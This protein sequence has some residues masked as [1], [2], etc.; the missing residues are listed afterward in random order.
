MY[1]TIVWVVLLL[2]VS[3]SF[4]Y[5]KDD[6]ALEAKG[7]ARFSDTVYVN[8]SITADREGTFGGIKSSGAS[9]ITDSSAS[10]VSVGS[11]LQAEK[12]LTS[13][14]TSNLEGDLILGGHLRRTSTRRAQA[15]STSF[16]G[17][18]STTGRGGDINFNAPNGN[19]E[20]QGP[21]N[22]NSNHS[23]NSSTVINGQAIF[24]G[25]L[26]TTGPVQTQNLRATELNAQTLNAQNIDTQN[27]QSTQSTV[28]NLNVIGTLTATNAATSSASAVV[29]EE[30]FSYDARFSRLSG[31]NSA[32]SVNN[33]NANQLNVGRDVSVSDAQTDG[34][35]QAGSLRVLGDSSLAGNT[36]TIGPNNGPV[37]VS[38]V[39]SSS[40]T[41]PQTFVTG[42]SSDCQN[43]GDINLQ[44]GS[45]TCPTAAPGV[46]GSVNIESSGSL[47][48][49]NIQTEQGDVNVASQ[50]TISGSSITFEDGL[51]VTRSLTLGTPS[52]EA[53][54]VTANAER[55]I[56]I[57][58]SNLNGTGGSL[59]L[60]G[61]SSGS[62]ANPNTTGEVSLVSA[63]NILVG[64]PDTSTIVAGNLAA[65][66]AT[67]D[68]VTI[69]GEA[70]SNTLVVD[71]SVNVASDVSLV[72]N[73]VAGT[74]L[75][76][77]TLGRGISRNN[78]APTTFDVQSP[79]FSI[80][81]GDA[82][83]RS[84]NGPNGGTVSLE[85]GYGTQTSGS[86]QITGGQISLSN[87][88]DQTRIEGQLIVDSL[89]VGSGL[90]LGEAKGDYTVAA[91]TS[92]LAIS[93]QSG[94]QG[95]DLILNSGNAGRLVVGPSA[96]AVNFAG[97]LNIQNNLQTSAV[98]A[99]TAVVGGDARVDGNTINLG[100][101][102]DVTLTRTPA[103]TALGHATI[104]SGQNAQI[105]QGGDLSLSAGA[106]LQSGSEGNVQFTGD[107]L[108]IRGQ[109]V[110]LNAPNSTV[111]FTST[112]RIQVAS[113]E[114]TTTVYG[115]LTQV[116]TGNAEF[117]KSV[118]ANSLNA[119]GSTVLSS[120][121]TSVGSV[122]A[123]SL[124][125]SGNL[126]VKGGVSSGNTTAGS[127][128]V[129]G[130][131]DGQSLSATDVD[132]S[133][134]VVS[135][136][137][138]VAANATV[139]HTLYIE[140]GATVG[141]AL[142]VSGLANL[143]TANAP[144]VTAESA[145]AQDLTA[146]GNVAVTGGQVRSAHVETG[147]LQATAITADQVYTE[148]AASVGGIYVF[149]NLNN[150]G[151]AVTATSATVQDMAEGFSVNAAT[152]LSVSLDAVVLEQAVVG[153][154]TTVANNLIAGKTAR[155]SGGLT[156]TSVAV[157]GTANLGS[158]EAQTLIASQPAVVAGTFSAN[159]TN[160]RSL[161]GV[162]DAPVTVNGP[163][164][165]GNSAVVS[166]NYVQNSGVFNVAGNLAANG[167]AVD[168]VLTNSGYIYSNALS[169]TNATFEVLEADRIS[170]A[171]LNIS[172]LFIQGDVSGGNLNAASAEVQ[173]TLSAS[174]INTENVTATEVDTNSALVSSVTANRAE[175]NGRTSIES[176]IVLNSESS[177]Q[178]FGAGNQG[179]NLNIGTSTNGDAI[180]L[181]ANLNVA[182]GSGNN[183]GSVYL[184]GN[185]VR[186]ISQ[187][188]SVS[189]DT[190]SPTSAQSSVSFSGVIQL[191]SSASDVNIAGNVAFN[192][193]LSATSISAAGASFAEELT[194]GSATISSLRAVAAE[195]DNVTFA[196]AQV[197]S[198]EADTLNGQN[199]NF[200]DAN[201][202]NSF[203]VEAASV[204]S[205]VV[206]E[207][208]FVSSDLSVRRGVVVG[209]DIIVNGQASLSNLVAGDVE[210]ETVSVDG[211]L[212]TG[213]AYFERDLSASGVS[214]FGRDLAVQGTLFPTNT[215]QAENNAFVYGNF[216]STAGDV[217][218]SGILNINSDF[219]VS[220]VNAR[221]SV[222]SAG[223]AN[224]AGSLNV[225][226][227]VAVGGDLSAASA[228]VNNLDVFVG[229][230][231]SEANV[232]GSLIVQGAASVSGEFSAASI[233]AESLSLG[234]AGTVS[235]DISVLGNAAFVGSLSLTESASIAGDL[236]IS[237]ALEAAGGLNVAGRTIVGG[238]LQAQ[239]I[240]SEGALTAGVVNVAGSVSTE[241]VLSVEQ[242]SSVTGNVTTLAYTTNSLEASASNV[243]F[244]IANTA[245]IVGGL[246]GN[247]VL[248]ARR[249]LSIGYTLNNTG[250][251]NALR[252]QV[253]GSFITNGLIQTGS[254]NIAGTAEVAGNIEA[255]DLMNMGGAEVA[256]LS[257]D[258]LTV[259][260]T[261]SGD[262]AEA[263]STSVDNLSVS[264]L[265]SVANLEA[266]GPV[267]IGCAASICAP[268]TTTSSLEV[269]S[270]LNIAG[271]ADVAGDVYVDGRTGITGDL[272]ARTLV[273]RN[274][275]FQGSLT[276]TGAPDFNGAVAADRI[277]A[278]S[279]DISG[280]TSDFVNTDRFTSTQAFV[281][282]GYTNI[283]GAGSVEGMLDAS[284]NS[285]LSEVTNNG[286]LAV[287][288]TLTTSEVNIGGNLIVQGAY[289]VAGTNFSDISDL[290]VS[291]TVFGFTGSA[292]RIFTNQLDA[293]ESAGL[294]NLQVNN[295]ARFAGLINAS[296]ANA[297][298]AN[299][300]TLTVRET[301]R[302]LNNV[303]GSD[304]DAD[305]INVGSRGATIARLYTGEIESAGN[306]ESE[307]DIFVGGVFSAANVS[308][309]GDLRAISLSASGDAFT[310]DLRVQGETN[311]TGSLNGSTGTFNAAQG[312]VINGTTS[313]SGTV[314][315]NA[316]L[317]QS[318][319]N[320]LDGILSISGNARLDG[321]EVNA[322]SF[323]LAGDLIVPTLNVSGQLSVVQDTSVRG[324]IAFGSDLSVRGGSAFTSANADTITVTRNAAV[325][326]D[327]QVSGN[328]SVGANFFI[329][330]NILAGAN[331]LSVASS[332]RAAQLFAG[333]ANAGAFSTNTFV[334]NN[335][336]A[337]NIQ[338]TATVDEFSVSAESNT[339]N[340]G[341][342]DLLIG[343]NGVTVTTIFNPL[344]NLLVQQNTEV[345]GDVNV[346]RDLIAGQAAVTFEISAESADVGQLSG[347]DATLDG[348][349]NVA[350]DLRV[351]GSL[352]ANNISV[353]S[354]SNSAGLNVDSCGA[355]FGGSVT[356]TGATNINSDLSV[357]GELNTQ[358][359]V[360]F[361]TLVA[362]EL[363][364]ESINAA[365]LT[366]SALLVAGDVS[367]TSVTSGTQV[368]TG[369]VSSQG[370]NAPLFNAGGSLTASGDATFTT[371][372]VSGED[373]RFGCAT[374]SVCGDLLVSDSATVSNLNV[375]GALNIAQS[376][377]VEGVATVANS[378]SVARQAV[379]SGLSVDSLSVS[380]STTV[381]GTLT[382]SSYNGQDLSVSGP[383]RFDSA[384]AASVS[385]DSVV[386]SSA[387]IGSA[388]AA[389]LNV[390][391]SSSFSGSASALSA[392]FGASLGVTGNFSVEGN[393][394][395][396]LF[397]ASDASVAGV[398]Y[399]ERVRT[400]SVTAPAVNAETV[401][402]FSL[403][404]SQADVNGL[405]NVQGSLSNDGPAMFSS[406]S[407]AG[408]L[409]IDGILATRDLVVGRTLTTTGNFGTTDINVETTAEFAGLVNADTIT[410]F[411]AANVRTNVNANSA[412]LTAESAQSSTLGVDTSLFLNGFDN[413]IA[414]LQ[415]QD[416]A[417]P[418]FSAQLLAATD[419][420]FN[421]SI[422]AQQV[423][424]VS[425]AAASF[426][427]FSSASA[428]STQ[429]ST[430]STGP[431]QVD[432]TLTA[433]TLNAN[434]N[435]V[436]GSF[437]TLANTTVSGALA[438]SSL[439]I[440]GDATA[441]NA[442]VGALASANT[443]NA[444]AVSSNEATFESLNLGSLNNA[445]STVANGDLD[446]TSVAAQELSANAASASLASIASAT[447]SSLNVTGNQTINGNLAVAS[448]LSALS[449]ELASLTVA[450]PI[451]GQGSTATTANDILLSNDLR[452]N[453]FII[454]RN[455]FVNNL[456]TQSL[457]VNTTGDFAETLRAGSLEIAED[458]Q[459]YGGLH[460]A[461]SVGSGDNVFSRTL[462]VP[463][464]EAADGTT[465]TFNSG[466]NSARSVRVA[467]AFN[468][469]ASQLFTTANLRSGA[470]TAE[471]AVSVAS[472]LYVR[473]EASVSGD[474]SAITGD[475]RIEGLTAESITLTQALVASGDIYVANSLIGTTGSLN[476]N[477]LN[478]RG[479]AS[480]ATA[481][482]GSV[483]ADA[484]FTT[485]SDLS[486]LGAITVQGSVLTGAD[487]TVGGSTTGINALA[488][489]GVAFVTSLTAPAVTGRFGEN[490]EVNGAT[491]AGSFSVS[492]STT[493]EAGLVANGASTFSGDVLVEEC[494]NVAASGPVTVGFNLVANGESAVVFGSNV[495]T[496]DTYANRHVA[497]TLQTVG[498]LTVAG[499]ASLGDV[500]VTGNL[501]GAA[502]AYVFGGEFS[503][504]SFNA[505]GTLNV[506]ND[507][508]VNGSVAVGGNLNVGGA[509]LVS[510][511]TVDGNSLALGDLVVLGASPNAIFHG[512]LTVAGF[513]SIENNLQVVD[514][515]FV[516]GQLCAGETDFRNNVFINQSL[517]N[518]GSTEANTMFVGQG[519]S[520]G[521][522][523]AENYNGQDILIQGPLTVTGSYSNSDPNFAWNIAGDFAVTN[524]P[525]TSE[526]LI[527]G[528][529]T[530]AGDFNSESM[531]VGRDAVL[532][533]QGVI[534][535]GTLNAGGRIFSVGDDTFV[536][537]TTVGGILSV[538]S[539]LD[540]VGTT[541]ILTGLTIGTTLGV[542]GQV[543]VGFDAS[544]AGNLIVPGD[545]TA[546]Q[547]A[548][549][550]VTSVT[551]VLSVGG[552]AAFSVFAEVGT[553][554]SISGD[555]TSA[556]TGS[557]SANII[558]TGDLVVEN[559]LTIGDDTLTVP[560]QLTADSL[561]VS[562]D[563]SIAGDAILGP[564]PL[565]VEG[566][567]TVAQALTVYGDATLTG[568]FS[569]TGDVS[570]LGNFLAGDVVSD[571][572]T[573]GGSFTTEDLTVG[574]DV[575]IR[576]S[577]TTMKRGVEF[578]LRTEHMNLTEGTTTFNGDATAKDLLLYSDTKL[579]VA[580]DLIAK[581]ALS[582]DKLSA[583]SL[584][585]NRLVISG[586]YIT[587]DDT[588][589]IIPVPLTVS[590]PTQV[591]ASLSVS[592]ATVSDLVAQQ[593]DISVMHV[594]GKA[595][596][597]T[598]FVVAQDLTV[599]GNLAH[600]SSITLGQTIFANG[601]ALSADSLAAN[602][603]RAG[604]S[605]LKGSVLVNGTLQ[606][607]SS[608]T[609]D[610][611]VGS[612]TANSHAVVQ[613]LSAVSATFTQSST[614]S[615]DVKV[616]GHLNAAHLQYQDLS[617]D[618]EIA[619]T[620]TTFAGSVVVAQNGAATK[621]L[622]TTTL[623]TA[624]KLT[625]SGLALSY[626]GAASTS[627]V[628]HRQPKKDLTECCLQYL[629]NFASASAHALSMTGYTL[630]ILNPVQANSVVYRFETAGTSAA[631][632]VYRYDV[633]DIIIVKGSPNEGHNVVIYDHQDAI[634]T[635]KGDEQG[636]G[637]IYN[638]RNLVSQALGSFNR[639]L[640][641]DEV[642]L[643][644]YSPRVNAGSINGQKV[645][646]EW[647]RVGLGDA[648]F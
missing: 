635:L 476:T 381:Q 119:Q 88:N 463:N 68:Q 519:V 361:G 595:N 203:S 521:S 415:S 547:V 133:K 418:T 545:L 586:S 499:S 224:F 482:I 524:G 134:L 104:F 506:N 621:T 403:T 603:I 428:G 324:D 340:A 226:S 267:T 516:T 610:T 139:L 146:A 67:F 561:T 311:I 336:G 297:N 388:S 349:L 208:M 378:A 377:S 176:G 636:R 81:A 18:D 533:A 238:S 313:I 290:T 124:S 13:A 301:T 103:N 173:G 600:P 591:S 279:A 101:Q 95:G 256:S 280:L 281:A 395:A 488:S 623:N 509:L 125:T 149:G 128:N 460:V 522:L 618:F 438:A 316:A 614:I 306:L 69:T 640:N 79:T 504:D 234:A 164:T 1:K 342:N 221:G 510:N 135:G 312:V 479:R 65:R 107:N 93:G 453:D 492:G 249:T 371:L 555:L 109:E 72:G 85:A 585:V 42:Q 606:G 475:M 163:V 87:K 489:E 263:A 546:D 202:Q 255:S 258:S 113:S 439:Q 41:P 59:I 487:L 599:S 405:V 601:A 335:G 577:G 480:F 15:S 305:S 232:D 112:S 57:A 285:A 532:G 411:D 274:G 517:S 172:N 637:N 643:Y 207:G 456:E 328:F 359:A 40:L 20:V 74:P 554:V 108:R 185:T 575:Y 326:A 483:A 630:N 449:S 337:V 191:G 118:Y 622:S 247:G 156:A 535:A 62:G 252:G 617:G 10:S 380:G 9:T 400:G 277:N 565:D 398:A 470:V 77:F 273:F 122:D 598:N 628:A 262:S 24:G 155:F 461:G 116:P 434:G 223:S 383:S 632:L 35:L 441:G 220:S 594:A 151:A 284:G 270:N 464:L 363:T 583:S 261:L 648:N 502:G 348:N 294:T 195:F 497:T 132:S 11:V 469:E 115:D 157:D 31:S 307:N 455:L 531:E 28:Q 424:G 200:G 177:R 22:I 106:A 2:C 235:G 293:T 611:V 272:T 332:A 257:A 269:S 117:A 333:A 626:N 292:D 83:S 240:T 572:Y 558:A 646:V 512:E 399:A 217:E 472:N 213:S 80:R 578:G 229:A 485:E 179:S 46:G 288:E 420:S 169:A 230:Q 330:G 260:G 593:A 100:S 196:S 96:S 581:G 6:V 447:L 26:E 52:N 370:I 358:S 616:A 442:R 385:A 347:T 556:G 365:S 245:S 562:S 110:Y 564:G 137:L 445:G 620:T 444:T 253:G 397:S 193:D 605:Q 102:A 121:R 317:L 468:A 584:N 355:N 73:L 541:T 523:S 39:A 357:D 76:S 537:A 592:N 48:S 242:Y 30:L 520:A 457:S 410:I 55:F 644:M 339:P 329:E 451:N 194:V 551:N 639:I 387:S 246:S 427:G 389:N 197:S 175:I 228:S 50:T 580:G 566:S 236:T 60:N 503:T 550:D 190:Q 608:N 513:T 549:G 94:T 528:A 384:Q 287:G 624:N 189:F 414:T 166:G 344:N 58:Q 432:S 159:V 425:L 310:N 325:E 254:T 412:T 64:S 98:T 209:N 576:N 544:V 130:E 211:R 271:D 298:A 567:F 154:A 231:A 144:S 498:D 346:G 140:N 29:G 145:K 182:G 227:D 143:N 291:G 416:I 597:R 477:E 417:A 401:Q 478:L 322:G 90:L 493:L 467:G 250:S 160:V 543:D 47:G 560:G 178:V 38:R 481:Q 536:G 518:E 131:F 205:S 192:G 204:G 54:I 286:N 353:S 571:F 538:G 170:A 56:I 374:T 396:A 568:L 63:Q 210:V 212:T 369:S 505:N 501:I 341:T 244:M 433:D 278:D 219:S 491:E 186:I 199:V 588:E 218:F 406:A 296:N 570:V 634:N 49:I 299:F 61:G 148:S 8:G 105:G 127:V 214:T 362:N 3:F 563:F 283:V 407:V 243:G 84:P 266:V 629:V 321:D 372:I 392:A 239:S 525:I 268:V 19:I 276:G 462:I 459:F 446:A 589:S 86:V 16:R 625:T 507:L 264:G 241:G 233:R 494:G 435:T 607:P 129:Y 126:Y 21:V 465:A 111:T 165:V 34:L 508:S 12:D 631:G 92:S 71:G 150:E 319:T 609:T 99:N 511:L 386:A 53:Y 604:L 66:E 171:N 368:T 390:A 557:I 548:I 613:E 33:A 338:N 23:Q 289:R 187:N 14:G 114:E 638:G 334:G 408:S 458:A 590:G 327:A 419:A 466:L 350:F 496:T 174:N 440:G 251:L 413:F 32:L 587:P 515:A 484:T 162:S 422:S 97:N 579:N 426:A 409:T 141:Q 136:P 573:V 596:V 78:S 206:V 215:I 25:S 89:A 27:L 138:A 437:A 642:F 302:V 5:G 495:T 376:A 450:G 183:A 120:G 569:I 530:V 421:E 188:G 167:L 360:F 161:N 393:L 282:T 356:N 248:S 429:A 37:F 44:G 527:A 514:N 539:N 612:L 70:S 314:T 354:A 552:N 379:L 645:A 574:R 486:V 331:N 619:N 303:V 540:G 473:D 147:S 529:T 471:G 142:T 198:I 259:S 275:A 404:A 452:T 402:T 304:V 526:S 534:V 345:I 351:A 423:S 500:D 430:L 17:Q 152:S 222:R 474:F 315:A 582:L 647:V 343:A 318:A 431:L 490:L 627:G 309:A 443:V 36:L 43:G 168:G 602:T 123:A 216:D 382:A 366:G 82:S 4:T 436:L 158:L 184:N 323:S 448:S 391:G 615:G 91:D 51:T 45:S 181:A 375:G 454:G 237:R 553:D 320:N 180:I 367:S 373:V 201:V 633:G 559:A 75:E 7:P 352:F 225:S 641:S 153:A 295:N 542:D 364:A 265:T 300:N 394:L 308:S